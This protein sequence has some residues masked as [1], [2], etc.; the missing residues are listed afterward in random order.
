MVMFRMVFMRKSTRQ[1]YLC[2]HSGTS[3]DDLGTV[4]IRACTCIFG[5]DGVVRSGES[6]DDEALHSSRSST[7]KT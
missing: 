6:D 7:T 4:A 3:G 2:T 1:R 5:L